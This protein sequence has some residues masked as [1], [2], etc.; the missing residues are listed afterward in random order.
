[1]AGRRGQRGAKRLDA[2]ALKELL[3]KMPLTTAMG[4]VRLFPGET[5]HFEIQTENGTADVMVDVELIPRGE[6]AFCRLGFGNQ[7]VYSIPKVDQEVAV[8]IPADPSSLIKD[9]L[10]FDPIIV[11]VLD[12]DAPAELTGDDIVVVKATTVHVVTED[13]I[14]LGTS[15]AA[16]DGAVVGSGIDPFTGSTYDAL[17][18]TSAITKIQK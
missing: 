17:G 1:M 2:N 4:V 18:N 5:S 11:A 7:G 16:M 15:P 9:E 3:A 8:L 14:K 12:L 10:D 6:R 13:S